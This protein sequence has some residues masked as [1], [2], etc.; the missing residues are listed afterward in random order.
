MQPGVLI[1]LPDRVY[2]FAGAPMADRYPT[3]LAEAITGV[4]LSPN[5]FNI[6][7]HGQ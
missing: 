5:G 3:A 7:V 4:E 2:D 6:D 1:N